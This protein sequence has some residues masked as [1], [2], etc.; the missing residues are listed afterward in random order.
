VSHIGLACRSETPILRNV[1]SSLCFV[2]YTN[3]PH[4]FDT[5]VEETIGGKTKRLMRKDC[6]PR[7]GS[8]KYGGWKDVF[9]PIK[10]VIGRAN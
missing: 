4:K 1:D 2:G 10:E 9:V 7:S 6:P 3:G 5:I 8:G